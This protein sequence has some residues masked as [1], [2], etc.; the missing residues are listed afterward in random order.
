MWQTSAGSQFRV[1]LKRC[2]RT[3]D[4]F[5]MSVQTRAKTLFSE[6]M[7]QWFL[8]GQKSLRF[9]EFKSQAQ[10][11]LSEFK[12]DLCRRFCYQKIRRM[13]FVFH[14]RWGSWMENSFCIRQ[15]RAWQWLQIDQSREHGSR[16][17]PPAL[18]ER[19][20]SNTCE[21]KGP[22]TDQI[23]DPASLWVIGRSMKS[24]KNTRV[25]LTAALKIWLWLN[26]R[27]VACKHALLILQLH[28][29]PPKI[30]WEPHR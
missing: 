9:H 15:R 3:S 20:R 7:I 8:Q 30:S 6:M 13:Q 2:G 19:S 18:P 28:T 14:G 24:S 16:P 10:L 12:D 21:M 1:R 26:L 29:M 23:A 25:W 5:S 27:P 4:R 11:A 17:G 22:E